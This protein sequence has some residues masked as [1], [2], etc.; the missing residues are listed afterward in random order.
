M[1]LK[2]IRKILNL[3]PVDIYRPL[4]ISR[5]QYFRLEKLAEIPQNYKY[6]ISRIIGDKITKL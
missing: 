1:T 4:G 5:A 6:G 2:E 3:Q